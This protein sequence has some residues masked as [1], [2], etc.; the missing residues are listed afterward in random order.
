MSTRGLDAAERN[1]QEREHE[2]TVTCMREHRA[3]WQV[4]QRLGNASA[5][6]GYRWTPSDYSCVQCTKP[7]CR[8]IWRT[9]A[10]YVRD[11]VDAP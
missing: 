5:F 2:R 3:F 9:K 10:A 6:N 7:L 1:R 4:L 11:L 8:R